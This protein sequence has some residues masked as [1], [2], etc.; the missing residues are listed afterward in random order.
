MATQSLLWTAL[1]NGYGPDGRLRV[2]VLLSPRLH[3][4]S[5][6][7]ALASFA[8]DWADWPATLK[9]ATVEVRCGAASVSIPLAQ[10]TGPSHV[11]STLGVPDSA[12]WKALFTPGLFVEGFVFDDH[13]NHLVL[14]YDTAGVAGLV[15]NLYTH[16]AATAGDS[17][18]T[19][20]EFVDSQPWAGLVA[21][22]ATLDRRFADHKTGLR[23]PRAQFDAFLGR[24]GSQEGDPAELLGR[25]QLFHT[26][27]STPKATTSIRTDDP[28]ISATWLEYEQTPLPDEDE[29]A[30]SLDFH[31]VV[32][33]MNQYPTLLRRLGLVV[34]LLIDAGAFPHAADALLSAAVSFPAG[35]LTVPRTPDASPR[36][37]VTL[38]ASVFE[39]RPNP[40]PLPGDL[41]LKSG[42]LDLASPQFD[43]LNVDVD[44]AGLKVMNFAR[45][46]FRMIPDD[47]RVDTVTRFE[48]TAGA[49][50]LRTAG[51]MLV[52]RKR[53]SMLESRFAVNKNNNDEAAD[54]FAGQPG[55][56]GPELWAQDLVRGFRI[57]VWDR[58]TAR[59][60]S[61]CRR[62]A[63]YDLGAGQVVLNIPDEETT[64]RLA[65]THSSDPSS[66]AKVLY[67]HEAL[68]SWTGW[69]L[70]A[71]QPGRA[72]LPDDSVDTNTA[73]TDAVI[74]PGLHLKTT[75]TAVKGSLPRLRFGR[76]YWMRG[77]VVDLAGNSLPPLEQD[78]G[79][80]APAQHARFFLR[81]EPLAAPAVAL[82]R[83]E[84]QP[85]ERPAEGESMEHLAVRTFNDVFD[86]PTPTGQ[87]ARRFL[88]PVQASVKDA[89]D[90][91][92][93]DV[94]GTVGAGL[95]NLL[96]HQKDRDAL[97]PGAALQEELLPMQ[98][99]LDP[100]PVDTTFAV[101]RDGQ[102]LTYLPDPLAEE[103]AVR[104]FDHPNISA[105]EIITVP[106]YPTGGWPEARPFKIRVFEHSTA[107]P[108]F[109]V[110][111][112]TLDVPL[113]K[114]TR[115]RVRVSMKLSDA[116]RQRFGLWHWLSTPQQTDLA[117]RVG[118]GQHWMFTPWRTLDVVHAVQRPLI[119][120]EISKLRID[121]WFAGT[122][123]RPTFET[124]CSLNSTD[125]LDLHAE[126]HEPQDDPAQPDSA[127]AQADRERGDVAFHVKITGPKAY[128]L[129]LHGEPRGGFPEHLV[130]GDDR[131]EVGTPHDL[132]PAKTHEFHDT[133]YRRIVYWLEATSSFR[134]YMPPHLLAAPGESG[135]E[136]TEEHIKVKGPEVVAWIPS[137][138]PP[139][140]PDVLYVVPTFGWVRTTDSQGKLSRW[141][142]G[143]GLRV[144]L[145]RPWN[146]SGYGEML[147][148]VLPPA[149][150]QGNPDVEPEGNPY[151][152]FVTQWGND[153][154]WLSPFV[155]GIAPKRGAFPLARTAAD[156][157]GSWLP[158]GAPAT[159]ADQPPGTF[160]ITN[161]V[162]P[163][164]PTFGPGAALV[165]LAP[166][167]VFYDPHRRLWYCDIEIQQG[168]SYYPFVRLALSRYQPT[169]VGGAY[170]SPVVLAD[171]MPLTADRWL[172]V[173]ETHNPKKRRVSVFGFRPSRSSG[174]DEAQAAQTLV[175]ADIAPTTVVE[176]WVERLDDA[177]GEDFG[178]ERVPSGSSGSSGRQ[179]VV[180]AVAPS[181]IV[182]TVSAAETARARDLAATRQFVDLAKA[183]TIDI[184]TAFAAIWSGDVTLPEVPGTGAR[185]RLV[186]AEYE[187]Y[188]VD[189]AQPYDEVPTAKGRRLVFV[190]H[191]ELA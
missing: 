70:A 57:D 143:G 2:S 161:L 60:R 103:V 26:P 151:R 58:T 108:S 72:V 16:L 178:W 142:R 78:Y 122:S 121:R 167:D 96:A 80:E 114:A 119:A 182:R 5:D 9:Q 53:R 49:P 40:A 41:P 69:S 165:E 51:L 181:P 19:V 68:V 61:L 104:I 187:E 158:E 153:P 148:V 157:A 164:L 56:L 47:Q 87:I 145:D 132:V 36:T 66:N 30:T 8:P 29:L 144:Y 82:V 39:A 18:P 135:P 110:A 52:Q 65:A 190:E 136:P 118:D 140:A 59:W 171:F 101:Y 92:A 175:P 32:A 107:K 168:A 86:D 63:V 38:S 7:P 102:A 155:S 130:V 50:A 166:H 77:R 31:Q 25:A 90:H 125:R 22:V 149:G 147:A 170:L 23:N 93:L 83:P 185:Y 74:P 54:V 146:V 188:L 133:R 169:S 45:S 179:D 112:N 11:D 79:P 100:A 141:R 89:E 150:F 124:T 126:W 138:A 134:E 173:S 76:Q 6:P 160:R 113:P 162:P 97:D 34:D 183:G 128:A 3:A 117:P 48:K 156:P 189:D 37:H 13:T 95:F 180:V 71:P 127:T 186:I 174:Y 94:N 28:R 62:Q 10:T 106:L 137:S 109:D 88:V 33:A 43:L 131:I 73:Q 163:G 91:G 20:S 27:P 172:T 139:P 85:T 176:V 191:V 116:A 105:S 152:R 42:L 99:P 46:L 67:L 184:V 75:F 55:A 154:V 129:R 44:G 111:A 35:V 21:A 81:F 14:S 12:A 123:A 115:A 159:E 84:G 15:Q 98:G 1:P 120:P 24:E 17:L 4:G 64:V 177:R